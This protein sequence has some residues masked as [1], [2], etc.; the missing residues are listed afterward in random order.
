ML[1]AVA[2]EPVAA[3]LLA[4][5]SVVPVNVACLQPSA[6]RMDAIELALENVAKNGINTIVLIRFSSEH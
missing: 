4:F 1:A 3:S 6:E 5:A 2:V